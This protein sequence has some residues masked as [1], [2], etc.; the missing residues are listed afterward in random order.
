MAIDARRVVQDFLDKLAHTANA[1]D[2]PAHMDLISKQVQ[3]YGVPGFAALGYDD[4]FKQC[5]HEFAENILKGV[6]FECVRIRVERPEQILFVVNE[7]IEA[8]VGEVIRQ[9]AEMLIGKEH[10]T[11]RLQQERLLGEEET[12]HYARFRG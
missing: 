9:T 12:A 10:D 8:T 5:Q 6:S 3:V 4:W 2:H 1:K 11:W 7:I